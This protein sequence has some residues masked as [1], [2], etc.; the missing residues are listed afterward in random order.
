MT[1]DITFYS[2]DLELKGHLYYPKDYKEDETYPVIV[3]CHGFAG[4]KELLLPNFANNFSN[5]GFFVFT[6]DYRG[7]GESEGN[8][9]VIIPSEQVRDIRS[10]I[11]YISSLKEVDSSKISLWGTS[12]GGANALVATALDERVKSLAVQITFA[13]GER[14]NTKGM[15][16]DEKDKFQ[17]MLIKAWT[18]S[19]TKNRVMKLPLK[20]VL[21][22][23][24]SKKFFDTHIE[25]FPEALAE[26][27]PFTTTLYINEHKP[28]EYF[29]K[30]KVPVLVTGA[31]ND[32]VNQ[33]SE[34]HEI[35]NRL[36]DIKKEIQMVEA[37]HYDIYYGENLEL[38]SN[39][40]AQWFKNNG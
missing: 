7:F 22:D 18:N 9:G 6:F 14:N 4:V 19:V 29:N 34:S 11:T 32:I 35:Y 17:Q 31:S 2:D 25:K 15:T 1:K 8:R 30:I 12:L 21:S 24:Q 23:S 33:P 5:E 26:T 39:K 38:V 10:A 13:N 16:P 40:Q 3:M 20:R 27:V 36:G 28:E 37:D